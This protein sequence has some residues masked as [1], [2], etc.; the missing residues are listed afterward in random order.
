MKKLI[1]LMIR[2]RTAFFHLFYFKSLC[3]RVMPKN[4]PIRC[5]FISR[6]MWK[7]QASF[8]RWLARPTCHSCVRI[9]ATATSGRAF[10]TSKIFTSAMWQRVLVFARRPIKSRAMS[11]SCS[12]VAKSRSNRRAQAWKPR[13]L[14]TRSTIG[15]R[16]N[17]HAIWSVSPTTTRNT[18]M[19][20]RRISSG[21]KRPISIWGENIILNKFHFW[22]QKH[23]SH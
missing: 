2:K 9:R 19:W 4:A 13:S 22:I 15:W 3:L 14:R 23:L 5:S 6:N 20:P 8:R 21:V 12:R 1:S 11:W 17:M 18:A 16:P 10:F 7:N